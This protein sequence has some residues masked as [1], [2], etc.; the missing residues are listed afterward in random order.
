MELQNEIEKVTPVRKELLG[1]KAYT[2]KVEVGKWFIFE[3]S[4]ASNSS[5]YGKV[6]K[7]ENDIVYAEKVF[8]I[9]NL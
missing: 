9:P 1:R 7:I 4:C 5:T 2:S 6:A 8:E 3:G